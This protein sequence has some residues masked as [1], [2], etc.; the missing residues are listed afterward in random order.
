MSYLTEILASAEAVKKLAADNAKSAAQTELKAQELAGQ[1]QDTYSSIVSNTR[2][3]EEQKAQAVLKI[4][5]RKAEVALAA[6]VDPAAETDRLIRLNKEVQE[7]GDARVKAI[8]GIAA[9]RTG[10]AGAGNAFTKSFVKAA[11][12][13]DYVTP[14]EKEL[15]LADGL[16]K[17]KNEQLQQLNANLQQSFTTL[18]G[19]TASLSAE[20]I[21]ALSE[22]AV[23]EVSL[24]ANKDAEEALKHN[25]T[26]LAAALGASKDVLQAA[27]TGLNARRGE[28][29]AGRARQ[30]H[31]LALEEAAIRRDLQQ[32]Q[33]Q[34]R[35]DKAGFDAMSLQWINKSRASLGLPALSGDSAKFALATL[36]DNKNMQTHWRHGQLISDAGGL[37]V[38]GGSPAQS[39]QLLETLGSNLTG[40]RKRIAD[41]L[42]QLRDQAVNQLRLDPKNPA[43]AGKI[44]EYINKAFQNQQEAPRN[45]K[46][47]IF[48]LGDIGPQLAMVPSL[49]SNPVVKKVLAPLAAKKVSLDDPSTVINLLVS[50]VRN[51]DITAT[52]AAQVSEVYQRLNEANLEAYGIREFGVTLKNE[53]RSYKA[54]MGFMKGQVDMTQPDDIMRHISKELAEKAIQQRGVLGAAYDKFTEDRK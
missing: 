17:A 35:K 3:I 39:V 42:I 44:N 33:L 38:V 25:G 16:F 10:L 23:L 32:E 8:E 41:S 22:N 13:G 54:G 12:G 14:G 6:G 46:D 28:E 30:M 37:A 18:N 11:G 43:T 15:S 2:V 1:R 27:Y 29:A 45:S 21:K 51:K 31:A 4:Q 36:K 53:G 47:N 20:S 19:L 24:K 40:N 5:Q 52:E 34:A 7:A 50:A 48:N 9:E 26:G 49:A